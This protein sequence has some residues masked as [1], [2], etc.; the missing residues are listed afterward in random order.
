MRSLLENHRRN[1]NLQ[2]LIGGHRGCKCEEQENSIKAMQIGL[3]RGADYLEIDVQLTK[4]NIPI[5]FH[6]II[7]DNKT[8]L[9][10]YVHQHSYSE[11]KKA[12]NVE[13]LEDVMK[14]GHK[15]NVYFALEL[16][17]DT[18]KTRESNLK[19]VGVMNEI[20]CQ[21]KMLNNVEA[22]GIDYTILNELKKINSEFET[23]L[24]VPFI[25]VNGPLFMK[26]HKAMV[27]LSYAF[28]LLPEAV[29]DLQKHGYFV[30]GAILHSQEHIDWAK[31][32]KVDMFEYDSPELL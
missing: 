12:Y 29:E 19:L 11:L 3:N 7:V 4:D 18:W 14:W 28:N 1:G 31:N 20:V 25:P 24:I 16:K 13:T 17:T 8:S 26:E 27:Y 30:S 21:E 5:I 23:G 32:I 22:F 9:T 2:P 15:N 6:D 10:G